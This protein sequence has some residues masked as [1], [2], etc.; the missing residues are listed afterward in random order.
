MTWRLCAALLPAAISFAQTCPSAEPIGLG[1]VGFLPSGPRYFASV[2]FDGSG[3]AHPVLIATG[4]FYRAGAAQAPGVALW[5]GAAWNALPP[6]PGFAGKPFAFDHSVYV[7]LDRYDGQA[8]TQLPAPVR[9][10]QAGAALSLSSYDPDGAGPQPA[11]LIGAFQFPGQV[12]G[13]FRFDGAAWTQ[14]GPDLH[15][16]GVHVDA[17]LVAFQPDPSAHQP[18]SVAHF[19]HTLV[20]LSPGHFFDFGEMDRLAGGSW[21]FVTGRFIFLPGALA[22]HDPDGP[23]PFPTALVIAGDDGVYTWD[24]NAVSPLGPGF[25]AL[26]VESYDSDGPGPGPPVLVAA[27]NLSTTATLVEWN[28]S[29]WA[30]FH[31]GVPL[32][33]GSAML[34]FDEDG[35]GRQ[36]LAITA[37]PASDGDLPCDGFALWRADHWAAASPRPNGT[38]RSLAI[39]NDGAGRK[40]FAAGSFDRVGPDPAY[41][42]ARWD[43]QSWTALPFAVEPTASLPAP[44]VNAMVVHNDGSGW[45]LYAA[46]A[47][48]SAGHC[49][50][51]NIAKWNGSQ[52][53]PVG[54]RGL[55]NGPVYALEVHDPDGNGPVPARLYAGGLFTLADGSPA[56][57]LAVWDGTH[58][59]EPAGGTDGAVRS[60]RSWDDGSGPALFVGGTPMTPAGLA[61]SPVAKLTAQGWQPVPRPGDNAGFVNALAIFDDGDGLR[62]HAAGGFLF[63]R[64]LSPLVRLDPSGWVSLGV[65]ESNPAAAPGLSLRNVAEESGNVLYLGATQG[66]WRLP[67]G[68]APLPVQD[69]A[70]NRTWAI[71]PSFD[72]GAGPMAF[73]SVDFWPF[74]YLSAARVVRIRPCARC[75]ANCDGSAVPPILNVNDF[76]CFQTRFAVGDTYANCD[77]STTSPTLNIADFLCF[78]ARFAAGCP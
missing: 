10:G 66:L 40:L 29:A 48:G 20:E 42:I 63:G 75:Y 46:G 43:G 33:P 74:A 64:N 18:S 36:S 23:G 50:V 67:P 76:L 57:H 9:N 77:A 24:G 59:S 11:S 4:P 52:W 54:Q 55:D 30:P 37:Y 26:S 21:S 31:G 62:L 41:N 39:F 25:S 69:A 51:S 49:Q 27:Q 78:Q 5:D 47:F 6:G 72:D 19:L 12:I 22:L 35:S 2:D 65:E 16:G 73:A 56:R 1:T 14:M 13:V 7:G 61:Q 70:T 68:Q 71:S 34:A 45:A 8:W 32:L 38:V 15:P 53:S 44:V 17:E 60:L 28:G 58:W 3:P